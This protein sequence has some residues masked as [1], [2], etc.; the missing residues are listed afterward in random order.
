MLQRTTRI[1]CRSLRLRQAAAA[2]GIA[3]S[4]Q[5]SYAQV[6]DAPAQKPK[7]KTHGGLKDQ[8]RI[9]SN[10]RSACAVL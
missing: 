10:V 4:S 1:A 7:A 2:R 9:F 6:Q 3:S 5:A 8:D